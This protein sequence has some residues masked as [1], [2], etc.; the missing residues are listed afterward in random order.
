MFSFVHGYARPYFLN[1]GILGKGE[2]A[3]PSLVLP[4]P[5]QHTRASSESQP[6]EEEEEIYTA[7]CCLVLMEV[8]II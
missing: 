8:A 1:K 5:L 3:A 4:K 2:T 6:H 7:L